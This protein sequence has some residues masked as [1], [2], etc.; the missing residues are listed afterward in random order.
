M[1]ISEDTD[2]GRNTIIIDKTSFQ[3]IALVKSFNTET[4]EA[5]IYVAVPSNPIPKYLS[6]DVNKIIYDKLAEDF[7]GTDQSIDYPPVTS[8]SKKR[9]MAKTENDVVIT[10]KC[11]LKDCA[12]FDRRT[13]EEI[14]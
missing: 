9:V 4:K 10:V 6:P 7:R 14:I 3:S 12:A 2:L 11:F 8:Y 5:E 1:I 13:G